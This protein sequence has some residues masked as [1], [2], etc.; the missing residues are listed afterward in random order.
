M[1]EE[2]T[3]KELKIK[4]VNDIYFEDKKVFTAASS[5]KTLEEMKAELRAQYGENKRITDGNYDE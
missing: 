4:W 1:L 2:V 3:E 5:S